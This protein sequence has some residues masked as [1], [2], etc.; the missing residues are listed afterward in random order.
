M[1]AKKYANYVQTRVLG[2]TNELPQIKDILRFDFKS[3]DY[4]WG[5]DIIV[6]YGAIDKPF[7]ALQEPHTHEYDEYVVLLGSNA[8]NLNEFD[9]EV[10]FC[11]GEEQEKY[12]IKSPAVVYC[13]A[14]LPHCPLNFKVVNK[15]ILV[16]TITLG[17]D[18]TRG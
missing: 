7:Y 2:K 15:P 4:K 3:S 14:R 11:L 16:M 17:K 13:P 10:E 8:M 1:A 6:G 9:A 5:S 12:V 18:Y